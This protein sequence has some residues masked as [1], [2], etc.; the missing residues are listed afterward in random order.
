MISGAETAGADVN[1]LCGAFNRDLFSLDIGKHLPFYLVIGVAD[2][3]S[4]NFALAA[5]FTTCQFRSPPFYLIKK[6]FL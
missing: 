6:Q 4:G 1:P 5:N 2:V 3:V